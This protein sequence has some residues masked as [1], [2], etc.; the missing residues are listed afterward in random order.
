MRRYFDRNQFCS[1][2]GWCYT[3]EWKLTRLKSSYANIELGMSSV[4]MEAIWWCGMNSA[5]I[6]QSGGAQRFGPVRSNAKDGVPERFRYRTIKEVSWILQLITARSC[7]NSPSF[8][9]CIDKHKV[10]TTATKSG[11]RTVQTFCR[12]IVVVQSPVLYRVVGRNDE[13]IF[14]EKSDHPVTLNRL[15]SFVLS[16]SRPRPLTGRNMTIALFSRLL[17]PDP[18]LFSPQSPSFACQRKCSPQP[19]PHPCLPN[20][21]IPMLRLRP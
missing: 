21:K 7:N 19:R 20:P 8:L 2:I 3:K 10:M 12:L 16:I 17:R 11:Q 4:P 15:E 13:A 18:S 9:I 14:F 1:S 6:Q 5:K